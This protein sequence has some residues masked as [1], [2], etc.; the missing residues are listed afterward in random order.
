M[1]YMPMSHS[2]HLSKDLCCNTHDQRDCM[3]KVLYTSAIESIM[4]AI[5]CT[6]SNVSFALSMTNRYQQ[7]LDEGH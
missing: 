5:L 1:G 4:Y 7:D 2:V 3:N 6:Q